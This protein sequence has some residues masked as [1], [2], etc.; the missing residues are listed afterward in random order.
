MK[1][2]KSVLSVILILN[3]LFIKAG[4]SYDS[5]RLEIKEYPGETIRKLRADE[6]LIY[7]SDVIEKEGILSSIFRTLGDFIEW[8][9]S[10]LNRITEE[11]PLIENILIG[12]SVLFIAFLIFKIFDSRLQ[13]FFEKNA[14]VKPVQWSVEKE[15]IHEIDFEKEISESLAKSQ[16]RLAVRLLYLQ[17]LKYLSDSGTIN[18]Q[19]GKTNFEYTFEIED[20]RQ[21]EHFQELSRQFNYVWYGHTEANQAVF[22]LAHEH[23]RSILSQED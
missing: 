4:D 11:W 14:S 21:R 8:I 19:E 2:F 23:S 5:T 15:N 18:W 3:A 7:P 20:L 12:L 13:G 16:Y 17:T 6:D 10:P 9:F 22:S 1:I